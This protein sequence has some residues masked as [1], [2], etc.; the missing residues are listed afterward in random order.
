MSKIYTIGD[1]REAIKD[2]DDYDSFLVEIHEGERSED[3]YT[4][5]IQIINNIK[6]KYGGTINEVRLCI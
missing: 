4:G 2:L 5:D 1:L 6:L 3:L